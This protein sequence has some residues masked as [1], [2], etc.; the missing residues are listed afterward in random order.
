MQI[1]RL[2]PE[3]KSRHVVWTNTFEKVTGFMNDL[4]FDSLWCSTHSH[5][6]AE[7]ETIIL[8]LLKKTQHEETNWTFY[9]LQR[10]FLDIKRSIFREDR[11]LRAKDSSS[12]RRRRRPINHC[13]HDFANR[14]NQSTSQLPEEEEIHLGHVT[15]HECGNFN[16]SIFP[17][18]DS[19]VRSYVRFKKNYDL[20]E[21]ACVLPGGVLFATPHFEDD[22]YQWEEGEKI[23]RKKKK[24]RVANL[25]TDEPIVD[26]NVEFG[27]SD[28]SFLSRHEYLLSKIVSMQQSN[29]QKK[30]KK[31]KR[32]ILMEI[33]KVRISTS[34]YAN[35]ALFFH[36]IMIYPTLYVCC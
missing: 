28:E 14:K 21:S 33:S 25:I 27:E 5:Q 9:Q 6:I 23:A 2:K 34:R 16:N 8:Q 4:L 26:D 30:S 15:I 1:N 18:L 20:L 3:W 12:T 13:R 11:R 7:L 17:L 22:V 19:N 29:N 24:T 10:S 35:R 36:I 31:K 32:V